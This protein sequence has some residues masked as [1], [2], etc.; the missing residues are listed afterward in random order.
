M[1]KDDII[2]QTTMNTVYS[3]YNVIII[4]F[5]FIYVSS[6]S[7]FSGHINIIRHEKQE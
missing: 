7:T 2:Y 6:Y 1:S 3:V 4:K 5:S